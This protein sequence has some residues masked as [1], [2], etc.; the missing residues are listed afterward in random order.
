VKMNESSPGAKRPRLS[1]EPF[2]SSTLRSRPPDAEGERHDSETASA[3]DGDGG[4]QVVKPKSRENKRRAGTEKVKYPEVIFHGKNASPIRIA[5]LQNLVLYTLADG[6]APN[7]LA[8]KHAR[9]TRKV[10][11]LMVP[12]LERGMFDGSIDLTGTQVDSVSRAAD[13]PHL[14]TQSRPTQGNRNLELWKQGKPGKDSESWPGNAVNIEKDRLPSP[15]RPVADI[16]DEVWPVKAPGDT[17]MAKIHSPLQAML[18]SPL[19]ASKVGK[20]HKG[21]R[22]P[23]EE[24][25][26]HSIRTPITTFI[27]SADE[28]HEA[29]YPIHPAAFTSTEDA[30]LEAERRQRTKQSYMHGWVDT[31][32]HV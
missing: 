23:V 29:E 31:A 21:P 5:D 18:V 16:F 13:D 10:V 30:A 22:P 32:V 9:H 25:T 17:K 24:R 8:F 15:V 12:G 6:V 1:P 2:N 26:F 19:P 4:W 14:N 28:L 20:D 3:N 27:H 11:V 7:W